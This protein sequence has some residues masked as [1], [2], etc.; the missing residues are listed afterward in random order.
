MM[1]P[2]TMRLCMH[3][4]IV[5]IFPPCADCLKCDLSVGDSMSLG[6]RGVLL[7]NRG[8]RHYHL[9]VRV[10]GRLMER[11]RALRLALA[12]HDLILNDEDAPVFSRLTGR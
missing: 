10:V 7:G 11:Y 8:A 9:V 1:M 2:N 5:C 12:E 6:P 4:A 3:F